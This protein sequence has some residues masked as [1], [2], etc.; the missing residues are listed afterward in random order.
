[1]DIGLILS[2]LKSVSSCSKL[3]EM[4]YE[5]RRIDSLYV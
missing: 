2:I 3:G 1:M 4:I 5:T